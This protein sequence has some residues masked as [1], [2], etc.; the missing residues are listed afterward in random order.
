MAV[1]FD[2][3]A[4]NESPADADGVPDVDPA[5]IR[6]GIYNGSG[7]EGAADSAAVSLDAATT[8][9]EGG[10]QIVEIGNAPRTDFAKTVVRYDSR[11][12]SAQERA[13]FI[14]AALPGARV[15]DRRVPDGVDVM[16]IVGAS[17]ETQRLVRID[18]IDLPAPSDPPPECSR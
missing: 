2:A 4:A 13:E 12:L 5:S 1:M 9:P 3:V 6:V 14:A 11:K 18:P 10:I 7:V 15:Q 16:V 17:F 8:F